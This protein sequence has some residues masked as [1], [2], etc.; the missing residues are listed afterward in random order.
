MTK[1]KTDFCV[2]CTEFDFCNDS[3][4]KKCER[5]KGNLDYS[6]KI[7]IKRFFYWLMK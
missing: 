1:V 2:Y 5:F 3:V 7:R 6:L 4:N